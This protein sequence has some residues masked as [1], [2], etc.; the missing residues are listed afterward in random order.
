MQKSLKK[1]SMIA[2]VVQPEDDVQEDRRDGRR[3]DVEEGD[4]LVRQPPRQPTHADVSEIEMHAVCSTD[5][6]DFLGWIRDT[7]YARPEN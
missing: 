7:P 4:R 5:I 6:R 3:Q 1:T 2:G